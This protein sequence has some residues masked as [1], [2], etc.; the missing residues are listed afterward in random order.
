MKTILV[1][2]CGLLLICIQG[3]AK[4]FLLEE[5]T[6]GATNVKPTNQPEKSSTKG[7]LLSESVPTVDA[8]NKNKDSNISSEDNNS[9]DEKNESYGSYGN[10]L[11]S[12]T[13]RHYNYITACQPYRENC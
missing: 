5:V 4:R 13:E 12:S 9:E 6:N 7:N 3:D 8:N 1:F 10:P 2:V 11:G